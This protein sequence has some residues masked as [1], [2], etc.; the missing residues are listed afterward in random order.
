MTIL[1]RADHCLLL[2]DGRKLA[3][4]EYR[5]KA[6]RGGEMLLRS[7]LDA[8]MLGKQ[9]LVD[10]LFSKYDLISSDVN[11][12]TEEFLSYIEQELQK[13]FAS[14]LARIR[15]HRIAARPA[16]PG[17]VEPAYGLDAAFPSWVEESAQHQ[18]L[19]APLPTGLSTSREFDRYLERRLPDF[20]S[21]EYS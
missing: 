2:L 16:R 1:K 3:S 5:Q 6:F 8:E 19:R 4:L 20:I 9:S 15:F 17:N 11:N 7:L 14:R 18:H 13:K 12:Q 21:K 10:V